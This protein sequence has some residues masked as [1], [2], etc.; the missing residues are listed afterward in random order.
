MAEQEFVEKGKWVNKR[1]K[2]FYG[3]LLRCRICNAEVLVGPTRQFRRRWWPSYR[4]DRTAYYAADFT[5][6]R[7]VGVS[8]GD[9]DSFE[10]ISCCA[11]KPP[12]QLEKAK[13]RGLSDGSWPDSVPTLTG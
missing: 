10:C 9:G 6:H 12:R 4:P 8:E 7:V 1:G 2:S 3:I 11:E 13:N 5:K